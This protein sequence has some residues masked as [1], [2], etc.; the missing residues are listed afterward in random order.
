MYRLI[1][2]IGSFAQR[3]PPFKPYPDAMVGYAEARVWC[4]GRAVRGRDLDVVGDEVACTA[5][6]MVLEVLAK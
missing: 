2:A 1:R 6:R 4:G 3:S 5:S